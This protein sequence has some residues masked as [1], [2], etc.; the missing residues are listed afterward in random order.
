MPTDRHMTG[1]RGGRTLCVGIT[2]GVGSGKS[3]VLDYIEQI[4]DSRVIRSDDEAKK[5]YTQDS[6]IFGKI[7]ETVGADI[8]DAGGALD[9]GKLAKK[10]F[11]DPT[12]RDKI[13]GIVHPAV[14]EILDRAIADAREKGGYD[15]LFIEAALLIECGYR[16]KLD[17]LW[18]VYASEDTRRR[19]LKESRGYDDARITSMMRAQLSDE[20]YRSSCNRVI[21]NDGSPEDMRRSVDRILSELTS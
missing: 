16:E 7:V 13:N 19:R 14:M 8:L 3:S 17:E 4:T 5:L 12:L 6:P 20:I 10:L 15:Y 11:D 18:Y 9:K 2:G 1:T 21:D